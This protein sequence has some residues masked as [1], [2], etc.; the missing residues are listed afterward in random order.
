MTCRET[1]HMSANCSVNMNYIGWCKKTS[2]TMHTITAR[3]L[4]GE[5]FPLAYL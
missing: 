1:T 4:Y 5:K 2:R 3:I